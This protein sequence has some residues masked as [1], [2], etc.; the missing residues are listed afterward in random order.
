MT[1]SL[2]LSDC[3]HPAVNSRLPDPPQSALPLLQIGDRSILTAEIVPLLNRYRLLPQLVREVVIDQAIADISCTVE[4]T[5]SACQQ[6]YQQ[7]QIHSDPDRQAWLDR[8]HL[9][10]N[11]LEHLITRSLRLEKFK[12][13]TWNHTLEPYFLKRKAQFDRVIYSLLRIQNANLAQELFF[14][15]QEGERSFAD[16]ARQH[17]QGPEAQT[18]GLV[19]PIELHT[20]HSGLGQKLIGTQPGHLLSPIPLGDWI[21]VV[22]LEKFLPAQLDAPMQQ[23]LLNEQFETWITEQLQAAQIRINQLY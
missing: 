1:L 19:G 15:I 6:F 23:R 10:L 3:P 18:G 20:L 2:P 8:N 17:S 4:E 9:S 7:N 12:Q 14:Q 21:V 16:L 5:F 13:T 11:E 22:R